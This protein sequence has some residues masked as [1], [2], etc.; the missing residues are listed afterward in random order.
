[1]A[2]RMSGALR[3]QAIRAVSRLRTKVSPLEEAAR[4]P[5][6]TVIVLC[7]RYGR[8]LPAAVQS[9]LAQED[10]DADVIIVDD[11]SPDDSPQ[12][13]ARLATDDRVRAILLDENGGPVAAFN[14]A[15]E[16]V[17]GEFVVRLDADDEL[18][19]G[20][21]ARAT[22]VLMANENVGFVYGRPHH[23]T[24]DTAPELEIGALSASVWNGV[25]WLRTRC[26]T[27]FNCMTSPEVV[28]R[29][30]LQRRLGGQ[31][32][33]LG[34]THDMEMWLR[35]AKHADVARIN[36]ADQAFI[37]IHSSSRMRTLYSTHFKDIQERWWA[38][39]RA[40][41]VETGADVGSLLPIAA[42]TLAA[43]ATNHVVDAIVRGKD[44]Q[45]E[46]GAYRELVVQLS[47]S[48]SRDGRESREFI[49]RERRAESSRAARLFE[50][51]GAARRVLRRRTANTYWRWSG[52]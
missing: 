49:R 36:G 15:L 11:A 45:G 43:E 40:F 26:D 9:V 7:Y 50:L 20:A 24:G 34:H 19:P 31:R 46:E 12:V 22:A 2:Q 41:G 16:D 52:L 4:I 51:I 6:V 30:D 38:F 10:V 1:M 21:L 35:A 44:L 17:E 28:M 39:Q 42:R 25:D 8:F 33:D 5:T 13:A 14:R 37:R 23:F 48:A 27:G 3:A 32:L 18:A 29:S 47:E